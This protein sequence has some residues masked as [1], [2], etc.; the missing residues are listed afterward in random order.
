VVKK[1]DLVGSAVEKTGMKKKDVEKIVNVLLETIT[2][3]LSRGEKVQVTGF[4]TFNVRAREAR[5]GRNPA[6]GE[7][8][9]IPAGKV[10]AFKAGKELRAKVK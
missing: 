8:V 3:S 10:P 9:Q 4:G 5:E 7:A 1:A 2:D 6:T